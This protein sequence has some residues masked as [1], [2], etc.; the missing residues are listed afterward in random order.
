MEEVVNES[1][2]SVVT[3]LE[4]AE[5]AAE[6]RDEASRVL[7]AVSNVEAFIRITDTDLELRI[8]DEAGGETVVSIFDGEDGTL[9]RQYP[10]DEML[11]ISRKITRQLNEFRD[12]LIHGRGASV[13]GIFTDTVV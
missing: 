5:Q 1:R 7:E 11:E 6:Q 3:A 4:I 12:S 10:T 9:L 8:D 13:H 2:S